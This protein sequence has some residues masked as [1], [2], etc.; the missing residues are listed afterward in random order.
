MS[1]RA[2]ANTVVVDATKSKLGIRIHEKKTMI[3]KKSTQKKIFSH[4]M[5]N[6]CSKKKHFKLRRVKIIY[7][8][9]GDTLCVDIRAVRPCT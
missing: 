1:I 2:K 6:E 5:R 7:P 3:A 8:E 4:R 9:T